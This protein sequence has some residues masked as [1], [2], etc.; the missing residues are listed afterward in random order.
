MPRAQPEL[1]WLDP[2]QTAAY[3][4][5]R[6]DQIRRLE[7][8]GKLPGASYHLGPRRPRY[9]RLK[10]DAMFDGGTASLDPDA[11]LGAYIDEIAQARARRQKNAR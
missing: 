1:R 3:I 7:R 8:A 9:D 4:S 5:V 11:A 10:I 2:E 6:V